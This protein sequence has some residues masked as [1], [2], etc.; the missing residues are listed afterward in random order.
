MLRAGGAVTRLELH[1]GM[2]IT[3]QISPFP[4]ISLCLHGA[5]TL[6]RSLTVQD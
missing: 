5:V 4:I 2:Q 6:S 3:V 1:S